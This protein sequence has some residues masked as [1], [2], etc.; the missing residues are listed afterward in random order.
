MPKD[1]P[2]LPYGRQ[3]ISPAD[4]SAVCS[5]LK[6]DYLTTGPKV[7]EFEASLCSFTGA[8]H[9]VAVNSGTSALDIAVASLG[10]PEGSEIITSPFTFVASA[11]AILYNGCKPVFADI[12]PRTFNIDP[13]EIEGKITGKTRAILYVDYAGQ[14]CKI[15]KIRQVAKKHRLMLIE[16]AAHALGAEYKGRKTGTFA[17]L[18]C[19]SFHPVKH[20]TTG[21]GGAVLT[22]SDTLASK[23]RM[24]RNHGI[25]KA[26]S[27][28]EGYLYDMKLLGRNYRITD[29]QCALGI[30]QMKKLP[31]F[32]KRRRELAEKYN[33]ALSEMPQVQLPAVLPH[34]K[35]A[36]HLYTVLLPAEIRDR[37]YHLMRG[38]GIGVNVHYIPIY[39]FSYYR[40]FGIKPSEY[41]VTEEVFSRI[42][43]LPLYPAMS[44]GDVL[45]V[46][47]S[48]KES[49]KEAEG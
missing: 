35:H 6:S 11:N 22:N 33:K 45:K 29:F 25:D 43:T 10:L 39:R 17:D 23:L 4:I 40:K 12:E 34:A 16:D 5:V 18:T 20:I 38:R 46:V 26:P 21:E 32:L 8:K 13:K 1:A 42:L 30:S 31:V 41:P 44:G 28:R 7:A 19:F 14:P 36:Y 48:L 49:L 15:E 3:S 9:A 47:K 37:V 27:Q 2:L 24:L